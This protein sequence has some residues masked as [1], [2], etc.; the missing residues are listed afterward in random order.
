MNYH[1][2]IEMLLLD[3]CKSLLLFFN[4]YLLGEAVLVTLCSIKQ[5]VLT[6]EICS[7]VF[8]SLSQTLYRCVLEDLYEFPTLEKDLKEFQKLLRRRQ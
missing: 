4:Q 8:T 1:P 3:A 6:S 2:Q 5:G 7:S